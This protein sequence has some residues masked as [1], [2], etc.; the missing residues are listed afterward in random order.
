MA[1]VNKYVNEWQRTRINAKRATDVDR[2]L[3]IVYGYLKYNNWAPQ[4][5]ERAI[6]WAEG[7]QRGYKAAKQVAAQEKIRVWIEEQN[8]HV[9]GPDPEEIEDRPM[10]QMES[11]TLIWLYVDLVNRSARWLAGS[12][13]HN[14]QEEYLDA[15]AAE[16]HRRGVGTAQFN[17]AEDKLREARA[18]YQEAQ[19]FG[20][21]REKHRFLY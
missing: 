10:S 4:P 2:K 6:N 9:N 12:Y 17:R 21:K 3:S 5:L 18:L 11:C 15:L 7:L 8:L 13:W 20:T 16:V 14:D 19:R 1:K